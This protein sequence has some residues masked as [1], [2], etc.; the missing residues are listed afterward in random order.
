MG[1][2]FGFITKTVL[3]KK[4]VLN[5]LNWKIVGG[6]NIQK[7]MISRQYQHKCYLETLTQK[8]FLFIF[9]KVGEIVCIR[10]YKFKFV[11]SNAQLHAIFSSFNKI[12]CDGRF[13][14]L[15][16]GVAGIQ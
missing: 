10:K 9:Y 2:F 4:R 11:Y 16:S 13:I 12:P 7:M 5:S 3:P 14:D 15:L 8:E 1:L 6:Y